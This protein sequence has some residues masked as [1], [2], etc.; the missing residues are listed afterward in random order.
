[1]TGPRSRFIRK[2]G[3]WTVNGSPIQPMKRSTL[4]RLAIALAIVALIIAQGL[5]ESS[6]GFT[7]NH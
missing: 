3:A 6:L 1:M 7:P 2:S 4:Q 5:L